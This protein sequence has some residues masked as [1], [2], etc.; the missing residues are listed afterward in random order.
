M[1]EGNSR[2]RGELWIKVG[3]VRQKK[4]KG[5][6]KIYVVENNRTTGKINFANKKE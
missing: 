3:R 5:T 2:V 1:G 4:S 6:L